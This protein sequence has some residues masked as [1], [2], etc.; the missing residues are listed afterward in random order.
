[1]AIAIV[2]Y[3]GIAL[4]TSLPMETDL[5][6]LTLPSSALWHITLGDLLLVIGLILLFL[7]IVAS[8][9]M[10]GSIINHGLALLVLIICVVEFLLVPACGTSTFLLLTLFTLVD[11]VAGFSVTVLA[12]RRDV[13]VDS[14][15]D[16]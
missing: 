16:H 13:V 5:F 14:G 3:N 7:E 4:L 6:R 10:R 15:L 8:S 1:M 2:I 9:N 11:V 12:A